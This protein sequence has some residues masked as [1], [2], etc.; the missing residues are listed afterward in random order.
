MSEHQVVMFRAVDAPLNDQQLAYAQKQSSRAEVSR[1]SF[2]VEYNYSEFRG[3]ADGLLRHG[4]DVFL[5][6]T[7]YGVRELKLRLPHGMP[8][9]KSVWDQYQPGR[10]FRW[11]SDP[12]GKG[13][14][15]TLEPFYDDSSIGD[16]WETETYLDAAVELRERLISGDLRTLY[17]LWLC[18]ASDDDNDPE[19]TIEPPVPHGIAEAD[20]YGDAILEFFGVDPVVLV[21]AGAGVAA[22]PEDESS[23]HSERWVSELDAKSTKEILLRLLTGDTAAEKAR[24]LAEIRDSQNPAGWPTDDKQRTLDELLKTAEVLR[25]EAIA[26]KKK[27]AEQKAKRD[28][29]KAEKARAERQK[30]MIKDPKKWLLAAEKAASVRGIENYAAAAEILYDLREALRS[31]E[32]NRITRECAAKLVSQ[33]PTLTHLRSQLRKRGLW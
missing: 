6:H 2:S 31:E 25:Q 26:K 30:E 23:N 12:K 9:P 29:E 28:A 1:W 24:V 5:Q 20:S 32:G 10:N 3:D 22:A 14:I 7:N 13:G 18:A 27:Q 21:A 8:F 19:E 11:E 15:L 33:Y 17:L 4:Y 16:I